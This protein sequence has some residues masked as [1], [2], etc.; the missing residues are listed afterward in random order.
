MNSPVP[1]EFEDEVAFISGVTSDAVVAATSYG[2]WSHAGENNPAT[3]DP[4]YAWYA[5]KWG[6]TTL[7]TSGTPGGNVTYWFDTASNWATPEQDAFVSALALWSAVA[8]IT[9]SPAADAASTDFTFIRGDDGSFQQFP[10][11]YASTVGSGTESGPSTGAFVE[12]DTT[13]GEF[14]TGGPLGGPFAENGG[15][16]TATIVHEIGHLLGL[17]HAGPYNGEVDPSTQQF[18]PYDTKLWS[19]MSYI[20]PDITNAQFFDQYTLTGTDW[21]VEGIKYY[22]ITPM[23]LDILR[24]NGSMARR[25][26]AAPSPTA[27]RRLGSIAM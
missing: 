4:D 2:T 25:N 26:R 27:D 16:P 19:L 20:F 23:I 17:G 5:T 18:G 7:S 24:C 8:D 22:S 10:N 15:Y 9:F 6:D 1:A 21:T 3:Y 14:G 13:N 12:I 11:R